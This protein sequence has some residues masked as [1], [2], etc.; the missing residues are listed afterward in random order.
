[1]YWYFIMTINC[2]VLLQLKLWRFLK[3]ELRN[4]QAQCLSMLISTISFTTNLHSCNNFLFCQC[5]FHTCLPACPSQ[6]HQHQQKHWCSNVQNIMFKYEIE[7]SM[8]RY[9]YMKI[10]E[11][12]N[13]LHHQFQW[14]NH[15]KK[16]LKLEIERNID[17]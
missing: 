7:D 13:I 15:L 9:S 14:K 16:Y 12:L 17:G 4:P 1:M 10:Y 11:V 3:S 6:H 2:K 5:Q 8:L